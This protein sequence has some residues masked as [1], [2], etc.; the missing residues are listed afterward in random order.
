L[1]GLWN[2]S[3]STCVFPTLLGENNDKI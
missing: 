3:V 1:I 2:K